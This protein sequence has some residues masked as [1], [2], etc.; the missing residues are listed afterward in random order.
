MFAPQF[1]CIFKGKG[2][3]FDFD[4]EMENRDHKLLRTRFAYGGETFNPA[5]AR[6]NAD[7]CIACGDCFEACTFKAI[8]AGEPYQVDGAR[9]DDCGS[10]HQVCPQ[11]AIEL[12]KTI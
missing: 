8:I 12:S 9:C 7:E 1:F 3:I 4:F 10:C 11:G 6:I 5:G 2:E